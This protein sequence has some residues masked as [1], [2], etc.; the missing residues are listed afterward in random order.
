MNV[1]NSSRHRL[2]LIGDSS[3]GKT[4]IRAQLIDHKFSQN[5]AA[6]V[7]ANSQIYIESINR[8]KKECKAEIQI[9]D[10]AGQEKFR[11]L[12]PI[13]FRN[14]S[15]ALAV[16]DMTNR[17]TFEHL[18]KWIESFRNVAGE[19]A[20]VYIVANKADLTE[21]IQIPFSE[22]KSFADKHG[23][24]IYETSA[25]TGQNIQKMFYEIAN[26]ILDVKNVNSLPII[27]NKPQTEE[28]NC[29]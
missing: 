4:C 9:W 19:N 6:T 21:E 10:T 2:V 22:A 24:M 12:G 1:D 11:S 14:A 27:E 17:T 7:G 16:F 15:G 3:V 26:Q 8:D 29:C 23:F 5:E 28:K 13:Y 25:K 20:L 18:G